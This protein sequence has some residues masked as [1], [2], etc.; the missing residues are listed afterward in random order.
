MHYNTLTIHQNSV[1]FCIM[2]NSLASPS[3]Q[4][5]TDTLGTL[6]LRVRTGRIKKS[7]SRRKLAEYSGVSERYL[8]LLESGTANPSI[9]VLKAIAMTLTLR[10]DDLVDDKSSQ[11]SN[12]IALRE[13]LRNVSENELHNLLTQTRNPIPLKKKNH[14]ALIG[15][16][17]AGKSTLGRGLEKRLGVH[18]LELGSEIA[19]AA[20]MPV[21]EIFSLGGQATYRRFQKEALVSVLDHHSASVIAV[22]GSL[23]TEPDT[24]ELLLK[25]CHTVWVQAKP[26]EHMERVIAQ[27]DYRPMSNNKNAMAELEAMLADRLSFYQRAEHAI[28]TS[29]LSISEALDLIVSLNIIDSNKE[30]I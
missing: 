18:F 2:M 28:D 19:K 29:G 13:H 14:V 20:G 10:V 6:G 17:G 1:L 7:M 15:L 11:S 23:V 5:V 16:R 3:T 9:L 30:K 12:Y 4:P 8:A 26:K 22:G 21:S 24:F 25:T 27:G